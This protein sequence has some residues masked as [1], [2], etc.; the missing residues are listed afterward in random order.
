MIFRYASCAA[1][2]SRGIRLAKPANQSE[3]RR[4]NP[5]VCGI[6][7]MAAFPPEPGLKSPSLTLAPAVA[8]TISPK[9]RYTLQNAA[10]S[11]RLYGAHRASGEALSRITR[12]SPPD[13]QSQLKR[14][15]DAFRREGQTSQIKDIRSTQRREFRA[16]V[17][18]PGR[19]RQGMVEGRSLIARGAVPSFAGC[20]GGHPKQHAHARRRLWR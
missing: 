14:L 12:L 4:A 16:E 3:P 7:P 1:T 9:E 6:V 20:Q 18:R 13:T 11:I 17:D 10:G 2:R 5:D 8:Q 15:S 19:W